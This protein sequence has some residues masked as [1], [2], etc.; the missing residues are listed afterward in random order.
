MAEDNIKDF[1]INWIILGLLT[2]SLMSFTITFMYN[3]NPLGLDANSS[4]KLSTTQTGLSSQLFKTEVD[5]DKVLNITAG[6]NPEASD[7]GSR[8]SVA[9]AYQTKESA[10]GFFESIKIFLSW[11]FVGEMGKML[12]A[13]FGGLIGFISAYFIIKWVRN[14]I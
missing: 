6:T 1:T 7:L 9:S 14:G 11:V 8:D 4:S 10:T 12:L 13:V 5:S 2:F 3:N